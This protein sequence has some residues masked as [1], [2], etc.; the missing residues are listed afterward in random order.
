MRRRAGAKVGGSL[1]HYVAI[2]VEG[3]GRKSRVVGVDMQ[4]R[5]ALLSAWTMHAACFSGNFVGVPHLSPMM[6]CIMAPN[7]PIQGGVGEGGG[8]QYSSVCL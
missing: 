6:R 8:K 5:L 4:Q 2:E 1:A 3:N 7:L